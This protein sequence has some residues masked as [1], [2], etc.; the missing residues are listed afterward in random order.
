M[1]TEALK[2]HRPELYPMNQLE[3]A[4]LPAVVYVTEHRVGVVSSRLELRSDW[5]Q[6]SIGWHPLPAI[7]RSPVAT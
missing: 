7:Y 1:N 4:D 5:C 2:R 3:E 6:E